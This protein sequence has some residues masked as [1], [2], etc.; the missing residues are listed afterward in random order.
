MTLR[1]PEL[2][3]LVLR[4]E[5]E[6]L[7]EALSRAS[8]LELRALH[9]SACALD[10]RIGGRFGFGPEDGPPTTEGQRTAAAA[11]RWAT[12][13]T[14]SGA[15]ARARRRRVPMV[16]VDVLARVAPP[17]WLDDAATIFV[18]GMPQNFAVA[19]ALVRRGLSRKPSVPEYVLGMI[20]GEHSMD[21]VLPRLEADPDLLE[22]EVWR[23]FEIEGSGEMS[24]A[25][26]DKYRAGAWT[27]ALVSLADDGRLPRARL[28]D[29]SL[30]ALGRDFGAFRAQW[31]ERFH[32]ELHPTIEE[33]TA[34]LE[35]YLR[36]LGSVNPTTVSFA[37]DA[38]SE[39]DRATPLRGEVAL[40]HLSS[41]M[42]ARTKR[43][44]HAALRLAAAI[45]AREPAHAGHV[46][47]L[48]LA[49]L[50]HEARAV[51]EDAIDLIDRFG[52]TPTD[53]LALR[54]EIAERV[55]LV[56][57]TLRARLAR[58]TD[59]ADAPAL[60]DAGPGPTSS[61]LARPTNASPLDPSRALVPIAA[62]DE[63]VLRIAKVLE[64]DADPDEVELCLDG[65][66][67]F[68]DAVRAP[69]SPMVKRARA[70]LARSDRVPPVS[71]QVARA[72][73]AVASGELE[74]TP[75]W[76]AS[77]LLL[78]LEAQV[79][80]V[81]R[82]AAKG[83]GVGRLSTPTHRG[84]WI[85]PVTL[86]ARV[87]SAGSA[88][89]ELDLCI[90]LLRLAPEGRQEAIAAIGVRAGEHFEALRHA[91]G[92]ETREIGP[93]APLWLAAARTRHPCADDARVDARH[94]GHGPDASRA[95]RLGWRTIERS[96][97]GRVHR[98]LAVER[99]VA[100]PPR[101]ALA[102]VA[103]RFH[104]GAGHDQPACGPSVGLVRWSATLWPAG[105]E[106]FFA[107][108]ARDLF[109][110][111]DWWEA[112]WEQAAYYERLLDPYL[113]FGPMALL[114]LAL[115]LAAKDPGGNA[116]AVDAAIA[117]IA[118]GG[119]SAETLGATMSEL[120][121]GGT[122]KLARW[123]K[124]LA[125]VAGESA[126]HRRV[127]ARTIERTLRGDPASAPRDEGALVE[128]LVEL[129]TELHERVEDPDAWSYLTAS[130]HRAKVRALAPTEAGR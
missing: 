76:M 45:A 72:I 67:R 98:E 55:A 124:S 102:H 85:A 10:E 92:G 90:A 19:R 48:A 109:A 104:L 120:R 2:E 39:I 29:A 114:V 51:Q 31:F 106:A 5:L 21:V 125:R 79:D 15:K 64:D 23:L 126:H 89:D 58:W 53:D 26:Y 40:R 80:D 17:A 49:A 52:A 1:E 110:N 62:P 105:S 117:A 8:D 100:V 70:L 9:D 101:A 66:A 115:G 74:R 97:E 82:R 128:L 20:V 44:A 36:L 47:R 37:L 116:L 30:A 127:V 12:T 7:L 71:L 69:K 34:R 27:A 38:L 41:A 122:I 78:V 14:A 84:G 65:L 96:Y 81:V 4:G 59:R 28:L 57:P 25:A 93:S 107:D 56:A 18:Q 77:G 42:T 112:R 63:L 94:P 33:R 24:L 6:P 88:W 68:P 35:A 16:T 73:A 119:V 108:G 32:E 121:S 99:G 11:A 113:H 83:D 3:Q 61:T 87:V 118:S 60:C 86:A 22:D 91:L 13:R 75:E 50:A 54:S 43:A 123:A 95:A 103:V 111:L 46:T 129:R 130:R